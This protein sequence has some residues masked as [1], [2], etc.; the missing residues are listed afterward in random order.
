VPLSNSTAHQA[1]NLPPGRQRPLLMPSGVIYWTRRR[2][3]GMSFC[4]LVFRRS[5][6]RLTQVYSQRA[7]GRK[8]AFTVIG[9][10]FRACTLRCLQGRRSRQGAISLCGAVFRPT[11]LAS[12]SRPTRNSWREVQEDP[13]Y[14]ETLKW[15]ISPEE[16]LHEN[17]AHTRP[18]WLLACEND[19][20]IPALK[21]RCRTKRPRVN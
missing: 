18:L 11:H 7:R 17:V 20:A 3:H 8:R 5:R 19:S 4:T 15:H 14:D 10:P 16:A 1:R 13:S 21:S 9:S 2:S 12:G 6:E